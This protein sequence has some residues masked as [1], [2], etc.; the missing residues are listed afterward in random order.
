MTTCLTHPS[1]RDERGAFAGR[2][3]LPTED[4]LNRNGYGVWSEG[5]GGIVYVDDCALAAA[6][7]AAAELAE[8]PDD[9]VRI[10]AMC[11]DHEEQPAGGC[12]EC[13]DETDDDFED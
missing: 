12:E 1:V 10:V 3:P 5:A 2:L 4:H 11:D 7:F 13:G 6:N 8:D 9:E